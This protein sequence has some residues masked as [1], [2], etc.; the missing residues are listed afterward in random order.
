MIPLSVSWDDIGGLVDAHERFLA[1]ALDTPVSVAATASEGG[2]WG[3]AVLAAYR[4]QSGV[5]LDAYLTDQ[6]FGDSGFETV[7]PDA[8]DVAGFSAYLERY[9]AGLAVEQTAVETLTDPQN[10]GATA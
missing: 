6:V 5:A 9:R 2:P 8:D 3:M 1:G 7:A 10:Q 4:L